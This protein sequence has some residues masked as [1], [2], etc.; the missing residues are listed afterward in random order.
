LGLFAREKT[1]AA[2]VYML[3]AFQ[4]FVARVILVL[5]A[6]GYWFGGV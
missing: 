3:A 5:L 4:W 1:K 2:G 6:M